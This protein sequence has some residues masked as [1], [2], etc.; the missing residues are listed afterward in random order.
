MT[1]NVAQDLVRQTSHEG[2]VVQN[3]E[4]GP[5]WTVMTAQKSQKSASLRKDAVDSSLAVKAQVVSKKVSLQ[6]AACPEACLVEIVV[7]TASSMFHSA[8]M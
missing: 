6:A 4:Y 1:W 7:Y 5:C 2:L 3:Q 8:Q